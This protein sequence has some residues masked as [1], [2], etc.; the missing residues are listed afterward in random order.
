MVVQAYF[1]DCNHPTATSTPE[2]YG[3]SSYQKKKKETYGGSQ[4][5]FID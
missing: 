1:S 3:G 5:D 4:A 2:T